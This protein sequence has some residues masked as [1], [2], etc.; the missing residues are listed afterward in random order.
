MNETKD[1]M[2]EAMNEEQKDIK[3]EE[4]NAS[5]GE[6][7][8]LGLSPSESLS[9]RKEDRYAS[10]RRNPL[11]EETFRGT[12]FLASD[13]EE[14]CLKAKMFELEL[15]CSRVANDDDIV[16]GHAPKTQSK[17][18]NGSHYRGVFKNGSKWQVSSQL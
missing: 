16:I 10:K 8:R 12:S 1:D 18:N 6:I 2:I 11:K 17:T 4:L 5:S 15:A 3:N 14:I 9:F 7:S 13:I